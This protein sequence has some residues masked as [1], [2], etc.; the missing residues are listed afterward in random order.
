MSGGLGA[1]V[2]R[3]LVA[4]HGVRSLLLVSRRGPAAEGAGELAAALEESGAHVTV[5]AC[6]VGDRTAVDALLAEIREILRTADLMT[7]TKKGIKQELERRFGVPLDAKKA[8]INSGM[9]NDIPPI[10]SKSPKKKEKHANSLCS[11]RGAVVRPVVIE[12]SHTPPLASLIMMLYTTCFT[13]I[14]T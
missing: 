9:Y 3:H 1:T 8:Y 7:I 6:D 11:Y 2:A 13:Y 5:A 10:T 4:E 14:H 12:R